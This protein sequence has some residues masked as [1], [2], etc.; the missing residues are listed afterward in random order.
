VLASGPYLETVLIYDMALQQLVQQLRDLATRTEGG[1]Q[2]PKN[3][4]AVIEEVK[5]FVQGFVAKKSSWWKDDYYRVNEEKGYETHVLSHDPD[6]TLAVIIV[7]WKVGKGVPPHNHGS[8]SVVMSLEGSE[9][10]VIWRRKDPAVNHSE[11]VKVSEATIT[12]G[13]FT[14]FEPDTIHSVMNAPDQRGVSLHIYG[15]HLPNATEFWIYPGGDPKDIAKYQPNP[16]MHRIP[17][18]V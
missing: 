17:V 1:I 16:D 6:A 9:T 14:S 7:T 3:C 13:E 12:P 4:P 8:W 2:H 11:L 5:G 15:W 18:K 10:N